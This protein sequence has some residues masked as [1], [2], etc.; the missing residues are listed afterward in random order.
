MAVVSGL[1]RSVVEANHQFATVA[2]AQS[3][4]RPD[5]LRLAFGA[6]WIDPVLCLDVESLGWPRDPL[7]DKCVINVHGH[8]PSSRGRARLVHFPAPIRLEAVQSLGI[9]ISALLRR[10]RAGWYL[11]S[12]RG[13]RND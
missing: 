6:G 13:R 3:E 4:C 10:A 8:W 5:N 1:Q 7:G 12:S 2:V 9:I 11:R